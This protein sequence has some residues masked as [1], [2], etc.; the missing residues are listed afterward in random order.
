VLERESS[1]EPAYNVGGGR[2]ITVRQLLDA[3]IAAADLPRDFPIRELGGSRS[4]QFGLYA[5]ISR[6]TRDFG[7]TPTVALADGLKRM[8]EWARSM[9]N[10]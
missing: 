8:V 2:P 4:D 1:P 3:L 7:W 10:A 6:A 5:D 9:Q